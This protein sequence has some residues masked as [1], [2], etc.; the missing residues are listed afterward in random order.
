MPILTAVLTHLDAPSVK[1]Q[2]RYLRTLAPDSRF[3]ICHGGRY[4]D[5]TA[6]DDRHVL[7]VDDP[8]LRGPHYDK[9]INQTL[10]AIYETCIRDDPSVDFLYLVEYD[11]LI[12]RTDFEAAL[13]EL[14]EQTGAGLLAKQAGPRNDSNWPHYLKTRGDG[15]LDRFIER[16]SQRDDTS[17]RLGCL[18]DGMLLR[19]DAL[20]ALCSIRDAPERYVEMYVPTLV[21]HLGFDVVD[22]DAV[23]DLYMTVRWLPEYSVD[24]A[25]ASKRA[26]KAFMHPFKQLDALD[27]I[28]RARRS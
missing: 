19:R 10:A 1:R 17:L 28:A 6:V 2:L 12:L 7:F 3:V 9:S 16:I 5:F 20:E 26:G 24:E 4:E 13:V 14:A 21:W 11:H 8:S 18:G 27:S 22:V 23:S 25:V 15:S